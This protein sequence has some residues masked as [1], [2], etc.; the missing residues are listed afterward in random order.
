MSTQI[1][2]PLTSGSKQARQVDVI[3]P[4]LV[5]RLFQ[6]GS[7]AEEFALAGSPITTSC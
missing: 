1:D 3:R 4:S 2:R 6:H 5:R 7:K